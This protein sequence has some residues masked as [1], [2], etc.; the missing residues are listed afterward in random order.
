MTSGLIN[1][2]L[3]NKV[4]VDQA[5]VGGGY[6]ALEDD[7]GG[8]FPSVEGAPLAFQESISKSTADGGYQFDTIAR[9]SSRATMR[10]VVL[11]L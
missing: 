10:R 1:S 5:G 6:V 11:L 9:S 4:D 3:L 8:S 2:G 7:S